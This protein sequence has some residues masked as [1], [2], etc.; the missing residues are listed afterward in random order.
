MIFLPYRPAL[1]WSDLNWSK[2]KGA[3]TPGKSASSGPNTTL[4]CFLFCL[5]RF[6]FKTPFLQ[7]NQKLLT[8]PHVCWSPYILKQG[9]QEVQKQANPTFVVNL[10]SF[11]D[12]V[13]SDTNAIWRN[14]WASNETMSYR[15]CNYDFQKIKSIDIKYFNL[16][17]MLVW[18]FNLAKYEL[19]VT[20]PIVVQRVEARFRTSV[21]ANS[22][23]R[24]FCS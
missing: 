10:Y 13:L 18:T 11:T 16:I 22:I 21:E 20:Y 1:T 17:T 19:F 5:V 14:L 9:K 23:R 6:A 4:L 15:F 7:V 12:L 24:H 2:F 8:K 3:F